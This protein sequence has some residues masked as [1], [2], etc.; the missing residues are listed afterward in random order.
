MS[1]LVASLIAPAFLDDRRRWGSW[2][3]N[4]EKIKESIVGTHVQYYCAVELDGRGMEPYEES[5]WLDAMKEASVNFETFTYNTGRTQIDTFSR[6]KHICMGRN[7]ISQVGIMDSTIS[8]ILALDGD[9]TP[10]ANILPNLLG[11]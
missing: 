10:P 7:I 1:I 2:L 5:G 9:V 6:I 8:H 4:H 3:T 11:S